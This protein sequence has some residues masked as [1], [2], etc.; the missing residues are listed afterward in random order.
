M[1]TVRLNGLSLLYVHLRSNQGDQTSRFDRDSPVLTDLVPVSQTA[2]L[3]TQKCPGLGMRP[4][5]D[6]LI[7]ALCNI[8][9]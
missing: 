7:R 3:G 1:S 5:R 4:R 8:Q 9:R 6:A 2:T